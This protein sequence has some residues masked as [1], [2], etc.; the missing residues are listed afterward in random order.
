[1]IIN[2]N[3]FAEDMRS[4]FKVMHLEAL[5]PIESESKTVYACNVIRGCRI[6]KNQ[7]LI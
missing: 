7:K 2:S 1:M 6:L 4:E 5:S 3:G